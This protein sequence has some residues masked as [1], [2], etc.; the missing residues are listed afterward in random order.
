MGGGAAAIQNGKPRGRVGW[1][2]V[3]G[4]VEFCLGDVELKSLLGCPS[5]EAHES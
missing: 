1:R 3:E 2:R 5:E 4:D